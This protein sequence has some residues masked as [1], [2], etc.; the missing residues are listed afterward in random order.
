MVE[1]AAIMAQRATEM[2]EIIRPDARSV[3]A[4]AFKQSLSSLRGTLKMLGLVAQHETNESN[5]SA[6]FAYA[7]RVETGVLT[8]AKRVL[9]LAMEQQGPL[10][11][12]ALASATDDT[13][14]RAAAEAAVFFFKLAADYARYVAECHTAPSVVAQHSDLALS[15]YSKARMVSAMH[16]PQAHPITLGVVLNFSVFLFEIRRCED[17]SYDLAQSAL[18]EAALSLLSHASVDRDAHAANGQPEPPQLTGSELRD[19]EAVQ[20]LIK[21]NL[22]VWAQVL[23]LS[24]GAAAS[25]GQR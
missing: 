6:V 15:C 5:L 25:T 10:C 12:D 3:I 19:S 22:R 16:L 2:N 17:E 13:A 24:A 1:I 11:E 7:R 18:E 14:R 8:L 4:I 9:I 23:E 21:E 20:G